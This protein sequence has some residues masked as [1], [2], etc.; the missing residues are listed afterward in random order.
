MYPTDGILTFSFPLGQWLGA[1]VR[2]SFLLPIVMLAMMWRLEHVAWGFVAGVVILYSLLL[3]EMAHVVLLR[4]TG[5]DVND[6]IIWPVGGLSAPHPGPG[7]RAELQPATAGPLMTAFLAACCAWPLNSVGLLNDLWNPFHGFTVNP[8]HSVSDTTLRIGFF[9]NYCLFL[10]NLIPITPMD[11]GQVVRSILHVRFEEG[12]VRDLMLRLGLVVSMV[13]VIGAFVFDL[14]SLVAVASFVFVLHLNEATRTAVS[15]AE[16]LRPRHNDF[17]AYD[18]SDSHS[19]REEMF[20]WDNEST[21]EFSEGAGSG[22]MDRWVAR[23]EQEQERRE[24]DLFRA[25][26]SQLDDILE[27]LHQQGRDAL[28]TQELAVLNRM[29]ERLRHRN[30]SM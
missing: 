20:S 4:L 28:N 29:S 22:I 26:Q 21:A 14:S 7:L 25:D 9:V 6:I 15:P 10:L 5:G 18:F 30:S 3:H 27:K 2:V 8:E 19:Y 16:G 13:G 17:A 1:R 23:R 11:A 24:Q 12:E